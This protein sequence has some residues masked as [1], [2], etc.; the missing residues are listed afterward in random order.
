[1]VAVG[2]IV[3]VPRH[4]GGHKAEQFTPELKWHKG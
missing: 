2:H 3:E 4:M 1:M